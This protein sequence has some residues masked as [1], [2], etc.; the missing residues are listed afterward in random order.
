MPPK[1]PTATKGVESLH[2][3]NG[4]EQ[5]P[6][7]VCDQG[8]DDSHFILSGDHSFLFF[9]T[10]GVRKHRKLSHLTLSLLLKKLYRFKDICVR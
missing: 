4:Q 5:V 1:P 7:L 6:D 2:H 10:T 9:I 3:G 8:V